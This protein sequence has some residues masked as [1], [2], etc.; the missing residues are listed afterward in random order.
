MSQRRGPP[1][2]NNVGTSRGGWSGKEGLD[3]QWRERIVSDLV[4][5]EVFVNSH[6]GSPPHQGTG[7]G[8]Q[9]D[10]EEEVTER[11]ATG[12][13]VRDRFVKPGR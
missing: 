2:T 5:R 12:G 13:T 8:V 11:G 4:K 7:G 1:G 3:F 6:G 9:L 10:Q